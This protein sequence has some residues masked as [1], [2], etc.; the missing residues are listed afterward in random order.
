MF[1]LVGPCVNLVSVFLL[2]GPCV[3]LVSV[4]LLVGLVGTWLAC[5]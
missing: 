3:N 4:F 1:L 5:S 2:V